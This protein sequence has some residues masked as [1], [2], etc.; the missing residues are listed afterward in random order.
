MNIVTTC[1]KMKFLPFLLFLIFSPNGVLSEKKRNVP[2]HIVI[3]V[4]D[5]L[6]EA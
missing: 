1:Y 5:D 3:I 2:P 6:G 4:I